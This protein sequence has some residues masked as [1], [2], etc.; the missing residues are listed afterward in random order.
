MA[1]PTFS[2]EILSNKPKFYRNNKR[3]SVL[4]SD[5]DDNMKSNYLRNKR[6]QERK[7]I[8]KKFKGAFTGG[9]S[10]GYNNTVGS[11]QGFT[12]TAVE[13]GGSFKK[14]TI[15]DYLDDEDIENEIGI[16]H[17]NKSAFQPE[18]TS[19]NHPKVEE[20]GVKTEIEKNMNTVVEIGMSKLGYNLKD[21]LT[22]NLLGF[23]NSCQ[24][25]NYSSI[26]NTGKVLLKDTISNLIGINEYENIS[27]STP[28][29]SKFSLFKKENNSQQDQYRSN[30]Y[31]NDL[32][33]YNDENE[34][35]LLGYNNKTSIQGSFELLAANYNKSKSKGGIEFNR[36]KNKT[37]DKEQIKELR[38]YLQN[39]PISFACNQYG[40]IEYLFNNT[41]N[42]LLDNEKD[43][44]A[45]ENSLSLNDNQN[46]ISK[47][48]LGGSSK[49]KLTP[50]IQKEV[51]RFL[52]LNNFFEKP[53]TKE[54]SGS[55]DNNGNKCVSYNTNTARDSDSIGL[56]NPTENNVLKDYCENINFDCKFNEFNNNH[57]EKIKIPHLE[58]NTHMMKTN[59][60]FNK[61]KNPEYVHDTGI[62][63]AQMNKLLFANESMMKPYQK[64]AQNQNK[65]IPEEA[66]YNKLDR[67][68][69]NFNRFNKKRMELERYKAN[70][71]KLNENSN[72]QSKDDYEHFD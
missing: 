33:E 5:N 42:D 7:E 40:F 29:L 3:L 2:Q 66:L 6:F 71:N 45:K 19:I 70:V 22:S 55:L 13:P 18:I 10:A 30:L 63:L 8:E 57:I 24:F 48:N 37:Y 17:K 51:N 49:V 31:E 21:S 69:K 52:N 44:I 53:V 47:D 16:V 15:E 68:E 59:N 58:D 12:P 32:E 4:I 67:Q 38:K 26:G 28:L 39:K 62:N 34:E 20:I 50:K 14:F 1:T 60:L 25:D 9:F 27:K 23:T 64:R 43:R 72:N 46:S 11:K 36:M 35:E 61:A 54:I 41:S 56:K 65:I